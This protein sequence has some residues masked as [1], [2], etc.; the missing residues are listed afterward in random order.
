MANRKMWARRPIGY[1]G[2][3]LDRG[4]VFELENAP[5]DEKL[6]RLGYVAELPRDTKPVECG[7]CGGKFY[8]ENMRAAHGKERHPDRF[9]ELSDEELEQEEDRRERL[10]EKVA[11][12][13]LEKTAASLK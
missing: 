2:R 12:L 4:Q 13:N 1:N 9:R 6:V 7:V 5:N 11:P 8:D 3:Q 10:L